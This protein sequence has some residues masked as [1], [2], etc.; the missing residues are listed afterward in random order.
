MGNPIAETDLDNDLPDSKK[1]EKY[2]YM[3][4]KCVSVL[5]TGSWPLSPWL[6]DDQTIWDLNVEPLRNQLQFSNDKAWW[7]RKCCATTAQFN[8]KLAQRKQ[9]MES[10]EEDLQNEGLPCFQECG[11][12]KIYVHC[13]DFCGQDGYCCR[14]GETTNG[15]DGMNGK[16]KERVCVGKKYLFKQPDQPTYIVPF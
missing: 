16:R 2:E 10:I 1:K 8:N 9:E 6:N 13:P 7:L 15:C 12:K 5:R 11:K 3:A 14:L 4:Q